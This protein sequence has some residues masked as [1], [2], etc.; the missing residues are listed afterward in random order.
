MGLLRKCR[1]ISNDDT[2]CDQAALT[3]KKLH[4][5]E[6]VLEKTKEEYNQNLKNALSNVS[7]IYFYR[8]TS[9]LHLNSVGVNGTLDRL[10]NVIKNYQDKVFVIEGHRDLPNIEDEN[11][12]LKRAQKIKTIL[13]S[14]GIPETQ[15]V[16][17]RRGD[18]FVQPLALDQLIDSKGLREYNQNMKVTIRVKK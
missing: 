7:K 9:E 6:K 2:A 12:D 15:L 1:E 13:E 10:V 8:N 17:V 14:K 4:E 18:K 11:V 5:K 16:I 3:L